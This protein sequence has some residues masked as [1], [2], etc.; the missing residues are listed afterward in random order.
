MPIANFPALWNALSE[1]ADIA[2]SR[3]DIDKH[4]TVAACVTLRTLPISILQFTRTRP[5]AVLLMLEMGPIPEEHGLAAWLA[6]MDGNSVLPGGD[7]PR[8]SRNPRTGDA[9]ML[10]PCTLADVSVH[11]VYE[12]AM[13]MEAVAYRWAKDPVPAGGAPSFYS[14]SGPVAGPREC[15]PGAVA[16]ATD[17]FHTLYRELCESAGMPAA[18]LPDGEIECEFPVRFTDADITVAHSP[19]R[20]PDAALIALRFAKLLPEVCIAHVLSMMD[21]NF[22]M[23][24]VPDGPILCRDAAGELLLTYA[25]PLKK[26]S[27]EHC[28]SQ[29]ASL[30][31]IASDWKKMMARTI[32][33]VF[34]H[35]VNELAMHA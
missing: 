6:L 17:R 18:A 21:A 24:M 8:F 7:S 29:M 15:E 2:P 5:D 26:S 4:G 31:T 11:D 16:A 27:G 9:V 35:S 14:F 23:G 28:L 33:V 1:L 25:Y 3:F 32:G 10:W 13:Q 34:P 30:V 22:V 19:L 12:R 20:N